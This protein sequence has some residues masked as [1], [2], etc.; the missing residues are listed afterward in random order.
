MGEVD[1]ELDSA[2]DW[3]SVRG[4]P[5]DGIILSGGQQ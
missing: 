1:S 3:D 5:L 2:V 4:E